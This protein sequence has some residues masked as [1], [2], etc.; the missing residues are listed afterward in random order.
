MSD[1]WWIAHA[2]KTGHD[3][4]YDDRAGMSCSDCPA[5]PPIP[6]ADSM[7]RRTMLAAWYGLPMDPADADELGRIFD[8]TPLYEVPRGVGPM[9]ENADDASPPAAMDGGA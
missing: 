4:I 7:T 1:P 8:A 9:S 3:T 5:L 2:R 6:H